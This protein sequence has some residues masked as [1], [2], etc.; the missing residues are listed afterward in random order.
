MLLAILI[1][2]SQVQ[3]RLDSDLDLIQYKKFQR[4]LRDLWKLSMAFEND[5]LMIFVSIVWQ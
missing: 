3:L 5:A 1:V 4:I 2:F